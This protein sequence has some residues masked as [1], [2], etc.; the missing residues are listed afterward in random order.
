[1]YGPGGVAIMVEA[2]T[3]NRNRTTAELRHTFQRNG[4]SLGESG[5]VSWIFSRKGYIL[6]SPEEKEDTVYNVA[7]EAEVE[8]IRNTEDGY[9]IITSVEN[10]EKV[11]DNCEKAGLKVIRAETTYLPNNTI[12]VESDA[13]RQL[14]RLLEQLEELDD[15]QKVYGNFDI[16]DEILINA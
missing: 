8:D 16:P 15:V 4:G 7:L 1:G 11:K 9:E 13:A 12:K 10:F 3:D 5:C 2:T 14:L 6:V